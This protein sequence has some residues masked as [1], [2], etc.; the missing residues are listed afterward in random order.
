[1]MRPSFSFGPGTNKVT[2]ENAPQVPRYNAGTPI[3]PLS[4][5]I[6]GRGGK[7]GVTWLSIPD[8]STRLVGLPDAYCSGLAA[9]AVWTESKFSHLESVGVNH[10][11]RML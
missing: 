3:A 10:L 2:H 8:G 7:T 4:S 11:A 1:M 6:I 5:G 9:S